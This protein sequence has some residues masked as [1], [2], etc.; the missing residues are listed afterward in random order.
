MDETENS[1]RRVRL[2]LEGIG[3]DVNR[4]GLLETPARVAQDVPADLRGPGPGSGVNI[5]GKA[6]PDRRAARWWWKRISPFYSTCEHHLLP[7][8]GKAHVAYLPE[9][10]VAGLQQAGPHGGGLR[11]PSPDPGEPDGADRGRSGAVPGAPEASWSCSRRS[12][13]A[14][15]CGGCRSRAPGP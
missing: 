13:C 6:V 11:P 7:F 3:E 14:C 5:S 8:W 1:R 10:K 2:F 4:E 12:T 15:P 9:G